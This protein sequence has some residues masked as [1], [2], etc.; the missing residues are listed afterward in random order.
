MNRKR[1]LDRAESTFWLF[2]RASSMNFAV[3]ADGRGLLDRDL[4]V[5]GLEEIRNRMPVLQA[6]IGHDQANAELFFQ[7]ATDQPVALREHALESFESSQYNQIVGDAIMEPFA[8][9]ESPLCRCGLLQG[10]DRFR[11]FLVFHHSIADGRSGLDLLRRL[12]SFLAGQDLP[13]SSA[14]FPG[15]MHSLLE[16]ESGLAPELEG[17]PELESH[18]AQPVSFF[19]KRSATVRTNLDEIKLNSGET[20]QLKENCKSHNATMHGVL[21]AAL[22][23][24]TLDLHRRYQN[25]GDTGTVLAR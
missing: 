18:P 4:L 9:D 15:G 5:Q 17:S 12:F 11:L 10:P 25:E 16:S 6:S 7:D 1:V 21:G 8:V 20:V 19:E 13:D 3:Y 23:N 2:D 22:L 14:E 24:A